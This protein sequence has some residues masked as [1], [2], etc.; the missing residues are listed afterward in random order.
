MCSSSS[1]LSIGPR[2]INAR[3]CGWCGS[4]ARYGPYNIEGFSSVWYLCDYCVDNVSGTDPAL[5]E[6]LDVHQGWSMSIS[7]GE[8]VVVAYPEDEQ[9]GH[10]HD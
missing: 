3:S 10:H 1:K 6:N 5:G 7:V 9:W 4:V 2:A 8:N